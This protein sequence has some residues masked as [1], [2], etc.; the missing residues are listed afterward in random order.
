MNRA[1]SGG[2]GGPAWERCLRVLEGGP[3]E[4]RTLSGC[5][6]SQ[7]PHAERQPAQSRHA[8]LV[9]LK[10]LCV[11]SQAEGED[12]SMCAVPGPCLYP[13]RCSAAPGRSQRRTG[14]GPDLLRSG[15]QPHFPAGSPPAASWASCSEVTWSSGLLLCFLTVPSPWGGLLLSYSTWP[16]PAGPAKSPSRAP[17]P[18]KASP[19][20]PCVPDQ[21]RSARR[22]TLHSLPVPG[23]V[24]A[25][26]LCECGSLITPGPGTL[27][28]IG[29]RLLNGLSLGLPA[30]KALDIRH[31]RPA[32]RLGGRFLTTLRLARCSWVPR[33]ALLPFQQVLSGLG[34][35]NGFQCALQ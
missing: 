32:Q 21:D 29:G 26:C 4:G 18:R 7:R 14:S 23:P 6:T 27:R 22:L 12:R 8:V 28:G 35:Q 13:L 25:G 1:L 30:V 9:V 10:H 20:P 3:P 15:G 31:A 33:K 17:S 24:P 2:Q 19:P 11:G 16:V 5:L 34:S